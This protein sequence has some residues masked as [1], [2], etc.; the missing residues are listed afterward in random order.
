M[1][2]GGCYVVVDVFFAY[3]EG[4]VKSE[5]QIVETE[6]CYVH[7]KCLDEILKLFFDFAVDEVRMGCRYGEDMVV[8]TLN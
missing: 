5:R 2:E 7:V 3:L 6:R 1:V 4:S 8:T